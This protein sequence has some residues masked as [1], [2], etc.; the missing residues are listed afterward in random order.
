MSDCSSSSLTGNLDAIVWR[1]L[2]NP[3]F[4]SVT[5][6]C[7]ALE[8]S[9]PRLLRLCQRAFGATPKSLLRRHRFERSMAQLK[10][11]SLRDWRRCID[12]QYVDQSHF[13]RDAHHFLGMAPGRYLAQ[14]DAMAA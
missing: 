2:T 13:I 7:D 1:C 8:M 9:H 6:I 3:D 10:T 14:C 11:Q 4:A 12:P 5:E